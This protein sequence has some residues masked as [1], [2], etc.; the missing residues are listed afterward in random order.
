M[1]FLLEKGYYKNSM[2]NNAR[3]AYENSIMPWSK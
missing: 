1:R 3:K 2:S